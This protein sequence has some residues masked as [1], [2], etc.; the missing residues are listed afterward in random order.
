MKTIALIGDGIAA[1][2]FLF[3]YYQERLHKDFE[4]TQFYAPDRAPAVTESS[5]AI[6]ALRG[7]ELGVSE[8]GD[9]IFQSYVDFKNFVSHA[10]PQ[11]VELIKHSTCWATD[12]ENDQKYSKRFPNFEVRG[13]TKYYEEEA[14][15]IYP[16]QLSASLKK[17]FTHRRQ[18]AL[19][20]NLQWQDNQWQVQTHDIEKFD[21]VLVCAG[22][23]S[24]WLLNDERTQK[25]K[26]AQGSFLVWKLDKKLSSFALSFEEINV[27]YREKTQELILGS[28]TMDN[29]YSFI[30]EIN[31]LQKLY[32]KYADHFQPDFLPAFEAAKIIT[33]LRHK[34]PKRLPYWGA[35][36]IGPQ[37]Y[38]IDSFYKNGWSFAFSA[39]LGIV[40]ILKTLDV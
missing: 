9:K 34:G 33:G 27:I 12:F 40:K 26:P 19:V 23:Y 39:A 8:L 28:T 36:P 38:Q 25:T 21:Y 29:G 10:K 18:E 20:K 15:L 31:K 37:A 16:T 3:T 11:G 22:A 6:V 14:F 13:Q 32:Q 35:A 30:P 4:L 7:V 17:P 5:T 2:A 24:P 1:Q